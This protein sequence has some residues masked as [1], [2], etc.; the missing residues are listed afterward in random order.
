MSCGRWPT[1][2]NNGVSGR[3]TAPVLLVVAAAVVVAGCSSM[4]VEPRNQV[5]HLRGPYNAAFFN[6][7]HDA[8]ARGAAF[9]FAH[10]KQHDVLELTPMDRADHW[11]RFFEAESVAVLLNPSRTEPSMMMYAPYVGRGMWKLYRAIDWTHMHHEQTYDILSDRSIP[12]DQKQSWTDRAVSYYLKYDSLARSPAPLDVTMR[13]AGVMMKPYFGAFRNNYSRSNNLFYVAHWWHPAVYEAMMIAGNGPQQEE[14]L[15]QLDEVMFQQVL[16]NRPQRMLL[17]REIMP[18]YSR[19][20]PESA[21]IFDNLHMLH[22]IAYDILAYEGWTLEQKRREM[23][24]VLEAMSEQPGDRELARKFPIP[25]PE[26]DPRVYADWLKGPQGE[27]SRIMMEM[28]EEMW[29]H[30]S[31]D[32]SGRVPGEVMDQVRMKLT[33]GMQDGEIEGSLH[34]AVMQIVPDMQMNPQ[35]MEPGVTPRMMI[36]AM[37]QGW[38][39]KHGDMPDVEPWPMDAEPPGVATGRAM[40]RAMRSSRR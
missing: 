29:P 10:G 37:L 36:D 38:Q 25:D 21:N 31:P 39:D 27:M 7:H 16:G 1:R 8:F 4:H 17:S 28:L 12:W 9:H 5:A 19:L 18:R 11:D 22:G 3:W 34:D 26:P 20:T 15:A 32:G 2:R 24:R 35:M 33:P 23:Y 13:R 30:M 6:R 14:A 40:S